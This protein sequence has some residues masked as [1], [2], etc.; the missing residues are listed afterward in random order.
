MTD[1]E[2]RNP[3]PD[4]AENDAFFP[5]PYSLSQYTSSKTDFDGVSDQKYD[6]GKWKIL[7]IATQERYM[8][9]QN[10]TFFSTGNH[11]VETLLPIHHM[12]QAGYGIDIATIDGDP[13]KFEWWAFPKDDD[14]VKSA[15]EATRDA[16]KDPKKLSEVLEGGL[17][18]YAAVF[19][20]GGHGAMNG[21]PF[22]SEVGTVLESFL[23]NDRLIITL[24]HGP[25]ALLTGG[26]GRDKNLFAGYKIVAFPDSLD[27]GA[28]IDIGYLPGKMPWDLGVALTDAGIEIVNDDMTGATTRDR[29]LL[30]GDSPLAANQLGKDSVAALL[31]QFGD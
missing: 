25:A 18:D 8:L 2:D 22:S 19:I 28:N 13:G 29:N 11:P 5:S 9:M 4:P 30:T 7:V 24:C 6:G 16:F 31:E 15:W 1:S 3:T 12:A 20:P 26:I 10:E 23:N 17:D 21:V 14:A 27:R